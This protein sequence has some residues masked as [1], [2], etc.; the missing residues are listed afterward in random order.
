M[1]I[2]GL[3]PLRTGAECL[4]KVGES[5]AGNAYFSR[6]IDR[7]KSRFDSMLADRLRY[8]SI[9]RLHY[10]GSEDVVKCQPTLVPTILVFFGNVVQVCSCGGDRGGILTVVIRHMFSL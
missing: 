4:V 9:G 8:S 1:A 10:A 2:S 5:A 7:K 6:K 3:G